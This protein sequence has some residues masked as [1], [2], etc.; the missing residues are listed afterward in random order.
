MKLKPPYYFLSKLRYC[1]VYWHKERQATKD[2]ATCRLM[3]LILFSVFCQCDKL[4]VTLLSKTI[5]NYSR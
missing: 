3:N 1:T 5:F 2:L 4:E